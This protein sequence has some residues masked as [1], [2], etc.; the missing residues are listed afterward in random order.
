MKMAFCANAAPAEGQAVCLASTNARSLPQRARWPRIFP[1]W[2]AE[3]VSS[4]IVGYS[5]LNLANGF[6]M[7]GSAFQAI[8][9]QNSIS[10]QEIKA[11]GLAGIDWDTFE[12][13]DTLMI[14][15]AAQQGYLTTLYYAGDVQTESMT[16]Y[17]VTAGTWFDM[18][19]FI[20]ATT[21]IPVGGAFWIVTDN[22]GTL[23]FK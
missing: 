14:W 17:G 10:V 21:E 5:K 6:T 9:G 3:V 11:S 16:G 8:G 23:T 19:N 7:V 2:A 15:D 20:P 13:G 4:N 12:P 22:G 1:A 18:N